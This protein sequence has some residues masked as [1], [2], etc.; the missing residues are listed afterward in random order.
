MTA[1]TL[2]IGGES[3]FP[4]MASAAILPLI[5]GFHLEILLFL[6]LQG[7]HFKEPVVAL[8]A[9]KALLNPVR[10]MRKKN[11]LHR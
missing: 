11:R 10:F 9:G 3:V 1:G 8:N 2:G 4:I 6:N 5:E 7:F